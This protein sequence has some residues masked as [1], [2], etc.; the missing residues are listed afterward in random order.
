M[1]TESEFARESPAIERAVLEKSGACVHVYGGRLLDGD[2]VRLLALSPTAAGEN[3]RERFRAVV[4]EWESCRDVD[5]VIPV[6]ARGETPRPWVATEPVEGTAL[7]GAHG[8]SPEVLR[9]VVADVAEVM[10]Q[11]HR[12]DA[13]F[14]FP[15]ADGI[16]L[17]DDGGRCAV[18][19]DWGLRTGVC[20]TPPGS[21]A[22]V[23]GASRFRRRAVTHL[24]EVLLEATPDDAPT[25]ESPDRMPA[26]SERTREAPVEIAQKALAPDPSER[27]GTPYDVKRALLFETAATTDRK[28][29]EPSGESTN[30]RADQTADGPV[31][32]SR[33]PAENRLTGRVDR[34]VALGVLGATL[35]GTGGLVATLGRGGDDSGES[36]APALTGELD[37]SAGGG[38]ERTPPPR[39]DGTAADSSGDDSSP[40]EQHVTGPLYGSYGRDGPETAF[41]GSVEGET[42]RLTHAG[43][44]NLHAPNVVLRGEVLADRAEL[45]WDRALWSTDGGTVTPGDDITVPIEGAGTLDVVWDGGGEQIELASFVVAAVPERQVPRRR[46]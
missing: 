46:S 43:G 37:R 1:G 15:P 31:S 24:G 3:A 8:I 41:E 7:A 42:F 35:L 9:A 30:S 10:E 39:R 17:R 5:G 36:S 28:G 12:R 21:S 32:P 13:Q 22:D 20:D 18:V 16:Y 44:N 33:F 45:R 4:S 2:E 34:R 23:T 29:C 19:A 11:A 6:L 40:P 14:C 26:E 38:E 25:G 27:Y